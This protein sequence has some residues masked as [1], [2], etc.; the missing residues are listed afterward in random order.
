MCDNAC[1]QSSPSF[2]T[3]IRRSKQLT[4]VAPPPALDRFA[5][6]FRQWTVFWAGNIFKTLDKIFPFGLQVTSSL[7]I[8]PIHTGAKDLLRRRSLCVSL[9]FVYSLC[10]EGIVACVVAECYITRKNR[11]KEELRV[12]I[13]Y[14]FKQETRLRLSSVE[15]RNETS[16]ES[17]PLKI[18]RTTYT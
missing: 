1:F 10:S 6:G 8:S 11:E 7:V 9:D 18:R 17:P 15:L 3:A 4:N 2:F 5:F 12:F 16:F 14:F 13:R